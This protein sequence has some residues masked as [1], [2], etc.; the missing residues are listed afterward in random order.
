MREKEFEKALD[1]CLERIRQ[2][3]SVDECLE[4]Y[5]QLAD[6]L[7]PFLRSA[8]TLRGLGVPE[9]STSG[10]QRARNN[11]LTRVAEGS[12]KEA[13]VVRGIFKF[14][15]LSGM[16]VAAVF[17]AGISLVAAAGPSLFGGGDNGQ[18]EFRATVVSAAPT[19]LYVQN[20]DNNQFVYLV[21]SSQTQ[22]RDQNGNAIGRTDVHVR[23]QVS[24]LAA[25]S[26]IGARF[27]DARTIR[28]GHEQS[29]SPT[30]APT[31]EPTPVPTPAVTAA[32]EPTPSPAP[33]PTNAP[34]TPKPTDKPKPAAPK[35]TEKPKPV[36]NPTI[37]EFWGV[38]LAVQPGS[39]VFQTDTGN[40]TV[41]VDGETKYLNGQ[42]F[43]GVKAWVYGARQ[44][45]GSVIAHKISLKTGEFGGTVTAVSGSTFKVNADGHEKTV[46]TNGGTAF[47]NGVPV[48]G[49]H[50]AVFAYKMGDGTY[51]AK[52]IEIKNDSL[53]F[54]GIIVEHMPAEFTLKVKVDGVVKIVCYEFG[55]VQGV[56]VVGATVYVEVDHIE[57]GTY[58]AGLVKVMS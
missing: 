27:F 12:G 57:A 58:F 3:G 7:S 38:V 1:E 28:L 45:D 56:L 9:P 20:N 18:V 34:A 2:G 30:A 52:K 21:L 25:Q 10:M 46:H 40:V 43:V 35:P 31:K 48:V 4:T 23:D 39:V 44:G 37:V 53:T 42:P 41:H 17:I 6:R 16:A 26:S 15:N 11:L 14:A 5:P 29:A 55:E 47:P 24:V 8:A 19:L 50:V 49:D 22:Y 32:P 13:A 54:T 33:E 51:V 36:T